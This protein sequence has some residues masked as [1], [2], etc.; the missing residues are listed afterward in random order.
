[1]DFNK[2]Q[3]AHLVSDLVGSRLFGKDSGFTVVALKASGD[4]LKLAQLAGPPPKLVE[5][6]IR[7][8]TSDFKDSVFRAINTKPF[9]QA[10]GNLS[11]N[12]SVII[13][14]IQELMTGYGLMAREQ[15]D[16][17][18]KGLWMTASAPSAKN[19]Q[20]AQARKEIGNQLAKFKLAELHM[21]D[22][23]NAVLHLVANALKPY[24]DFLSAPGGFEKFNTLF[25]DVIEQKKMDTKVLKSITD[26]AIKAVAEESKVAEPKAE[27][28]TAE[29]T[30]KPSWTPPTS[31]EPIVKAGIEGGKKLLDGISPLAKAMPKISASFANAET[32]TQKV[33]TEFATMIKA[34]PGIGNKVDQDALTEFLSLV[35]VLQAL[36]LSNAATE[37]EASKKVWKDAAKRLSRLAWFG[38]SWQTMKSMTRVASLVTKMGGGLMGSRLAAELYP[39][40]EQAWRDRVKSVA[41][42]NNQP[43]FDKVSANPAILSQPAVLEQEIGAKDTMANTMRAL[44]TLDWLGRGGFTADEIVGKLLGQVGTDPKNVLNADT[45]SVMASILFRLRRQTQPSYGFG[46][47]WD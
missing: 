18:V 41:S 4:F 15:I 30:D 27:P 33:A 40:L 36:M 11:N 29:T 47:S 42:K 9:Y 16:N 13:R 23:S 26:A 17:L 37:D 10:A 6:D 21:N 12:A 3:Y 38:D 7:K 5:R 25:P 14:A 31:Y 32:E 44:H 20:K 1:M 24:E 28:G 39:K 35:F 34:D 2:A 43:V 46:N 22:P 45:M 19:S 8:K